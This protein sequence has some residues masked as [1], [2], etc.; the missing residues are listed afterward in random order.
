MLF[1]DEVD[2]FDAE[3]EKPAIQSTD[4]EDDDGITV[5]TRLH[6]ARRLAYYAVAGVFFVLAFQRRVLHATPAHCFTWPSVLLKQ[7]HL[8]SSIEVL[9]GLILMLLPAVL[10]SSGQ[11]PLHTFDIALMAGAATLL[12]IMHLILKQ[13]ELVLMEERDRQH[14]IATGEEIM[15][16]ASAVAREWTESFGSEISRGFRGAG[17]G[18]KRSSSSSSSSSGNNS[19]RFYRVEGTVESMDVTDGLERQAAYWNKDEASALMGGLGDG[20]RG[21]LDLKNDEQ[22]GISYPAPSAPPLSPDWN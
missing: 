22:S 5:A 21:S 7:H 15:A 17:M 10:P 19:S 6:F 14:A 1:Q 11:G 16:A 18:S 12:V 4:G 8:K 9:T 20:N 13:R 3:N 2:R